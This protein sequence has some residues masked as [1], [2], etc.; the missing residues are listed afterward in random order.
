MK[1]E[2]DQIGKRLYETGVDRGVVYPFTSGHYE[3][4][5][6]WNGLTAVNES[7][8]GA[9]PTA[10]YADN[11]KYV[12]VLSKEELGLGVEAYSYPEVMEQFLGRTILISGVTIGQQN[13]KKFG[14]CYRTLVGD[15]I[16]GNDAGYKIHVVLRCLASPSEESRNTMNDTPEAEGYSWTFDTTPLKIDEEREAAQMVF[17]SREFI[18]AGI[19]NVL[20]ALENT[21]YGTETTNPTM[22]TFS[23]VDEIFTEHMYLS[24]SNG[25]NILDS[26]GNQIRTFV[27]D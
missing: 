13:R 12:N 20:R 18:K 22:L 17:H 3:N 19:P 7:P 23:S 24:D 4:G 2:W 9:E 11:G 14:F 15:D 6:A 27:I 26:S 21:L 8:S 5:V 25:N 1:L 10:L 16:D